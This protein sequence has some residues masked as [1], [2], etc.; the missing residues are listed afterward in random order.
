[1]Y[2]PNTSSNDFSSGNDSYNG[3]DTSSG[4][5]WIQQP[6]YSD[7]IPWYNND[8]SDVNG[9]N[10]PGGPSRSSAGGQYPNRPNQQPSAPSHPPP[11]NGNSAH[12]GTSNPSGSQ[13]RNVSESIGNH[14]SPEVADG[15]KSSKTSLKKKKRKTGGSEA[16]AA[17][18]EA[19]KEK[20]TKTGR[21]CDACVSARKRFRGCPA[22]CRRGFKGGDKT[23]RAMRY[24]RT[25]KIRCDILPSEASNGGREPR[26]ICA[27]CKQYDLECTFFLPITET[28]FKKRKA[29][30]ELKFVKVVGFMLR[31]TTFLEDQVEPTVSFKHSTTSS[32]RDLAPREVPTRTEGECFLSLPP[33]GSPGKHP[34]DP[35]VQVPRR[36]HSSYTPRCLRVLLRLTIFENTT[37]G[38]YQKAETA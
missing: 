5:P 34:S 15:A 27:H 18:A 9:Q 31:L 32:P 33:L 3:Y 11:A 1:M 23:Y 10:Q 35:L 36:Y 4:Q 20:R 7:P 25:K 16:D 38:R 37:V 17:D 22:G 29:T 30:G 8:S 2:G 26:P 24:Q 14:S 13:M 6:G 28:R 21:A 19:D 12:S